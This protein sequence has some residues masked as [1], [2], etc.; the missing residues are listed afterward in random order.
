MTTEPEKTFT[1][2]DLNRASRGSGPNL[3]ELADFICRRSREYEQLLGVNADKPDYGRFA[4]DPLF[5]GMSPNVNGDFIDAYRVD[6]RVEEDNSKWERRLVP[7]DFVYK[8]D[9]FIAKFEQAAPNTADFDI[10]TPL[11][12]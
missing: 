2:E 11:V 4:N 7:F 1:V 3:L 6:V 9:E 12:K 5:V 10:L 8:K